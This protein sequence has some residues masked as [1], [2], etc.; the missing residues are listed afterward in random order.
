MIKFWRRSYKIGKLL[1]TQLTLWKQSYWLWWLIIISSKTYKLH[2]KGCDVYFLKISDLLSKSSYL[3]CWRPWKIVIKSFFFLFFVKFP[4]WYI[5]IYIYI[6]LF[7]FFFLRIHFVQVRFFFFFLLSKY[8]KSNL[9][10]RRFQRLL[11]WAN[12]GCLIII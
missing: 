10:M 12:W 1:R 5:Y 3:A 11:N 6:F 9:I 4:I 2:W 8:I 7:F